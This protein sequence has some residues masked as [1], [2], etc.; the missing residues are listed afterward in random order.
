MP[1]Q[2]RACEKRPEERAEQGT[3][4]PLCIQGGSDA[5]AA[6]RQTV[7][8]AHLC[9]LHIAHMLCAHSFTLLS[10]KTK[11]NQVS[12]RKQTVSSKHSHVFL[13][14]EGRSDKARNETFGVST[15]W[16]SFPQ[17]TIDSYYAANVHTRMTEWKIL[18]WRTPCMWRTLHTRMT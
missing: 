14:W 1:S 2:T 13:W 7:T 3:E 9:H 11:Q 12:L 17:H 10:Q 18:L 6:L 5:A 8:S 15:S 4:Y 16:A